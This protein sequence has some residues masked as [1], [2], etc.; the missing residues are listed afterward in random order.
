MAA[1]VIAIGEVG[2]GDP[3]WYRP[4][5]TRWVFERQQG[6][7]EILAPN[8]EVAA[9]TMRQ[10]GFTGVQAHMLKRQASYTVPP[11]SMDGES[12]PPKSQK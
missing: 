7:L 5:L 2:K 12:K 9:A 1:L 4:K 8:A 3:G 10:Y 11:V 6:D